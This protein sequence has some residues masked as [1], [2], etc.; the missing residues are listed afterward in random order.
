[1]SR[2]QNEDISG[3]VRSVMAVS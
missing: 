2:Q 1:M 3:I